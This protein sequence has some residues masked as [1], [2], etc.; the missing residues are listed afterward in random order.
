[1]ISWLEHEKLFYNLGAKSHIFYPW[2]FQ[3]VR[4]G[5]KIKAVTHLHMTLAVAVML[6]T[7]KQTHTQSEATVT[8]FYS[9]TKVLGQDSQ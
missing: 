9:G 3:A 6:N 8:H 2:L 1:M 7:N 5:L 4:W